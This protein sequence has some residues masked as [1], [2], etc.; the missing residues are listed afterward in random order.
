MYIPEQ[1]IRGSYKDPSGYV[2]QKD[3]QLFRRINKC[4]LDTYHLVRDSGLFQELIQKKLLIEHDEILE[5]GEDDPHAIIRPR[6]IQ[7]ITYPYEWCFSQLRDAALATLTIQSMAIS[8]GFT[9]KDAHG[10]NIQ[11]DGG[12]PILIDT[13]SF[14]RWEHTPWEAYR[15]FCES[16]LIPLALMRYRSQH[17]NILLTKFLDGIPLE[18]GSG[19]LPLRTRLSIPLLMH[20]HL[21]ASRA[22]ADAKADKTSPEFKSSRS[23]SEQSMLG[24]C[25]SLENAIRSIKPPDIESVWNTYYQKSCI[26]S[27]DAFEQKKHFITLV[28]EEQRPSVVWDLGCNIGEFSL[29]AAKYCDLVV[30]IDSDPACIERL[31]QHCKT[32]QIA[33]ILPLQMDLVNPSAALGWELEERLSLFERGGCDLAFALALIHHLCISANIPMDYVARFFGRVSNRLI[34]EFVPKDDPQVKVLLS[35]RKDIFTNYNRLAFESAFEQYFR[36][37]HEKQLADSNRT[38]YYMERK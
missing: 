31:Y 29:L 17:L 33:N 7:F 6:M 10:F 30:A 23:F 32:E 13:L 11:F 19:L 8:R 12:L 18:I 36:I 14:D 4:Y 20:V 38:L 25:M 27:Q 9:L 5:Q 35:S 15:Q 3:G 1:K 16:F 28:A 34:I 22:V 21:H 24:L 26:Y 2:F 37:I